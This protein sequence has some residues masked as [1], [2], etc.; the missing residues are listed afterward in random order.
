MDK[1]DKKITNKILPKFTNAKEWPDLMTILKNLKNN[2]NKYSTSNMGILT[3]RVTL[4]KRLAQ[5][6]NPS[7][8]GGLHEMA[9]EIYSMLYDNIK[10]YNN[11][12]LGDNLG[13]YSSGLF[14]FFIYAS[15][16]NKIKF[17]E[18]IIKKHYLTL[19]KCEFKLCLSGC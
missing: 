13:L 17:L 10:K 9:L 12:L 6:L 11:N 15:A 19:E 1:F 7:V 18:N 16:Q 2:L 8:P 5:C 4:S 3:D 14:P